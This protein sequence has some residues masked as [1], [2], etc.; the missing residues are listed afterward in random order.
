MKIIVC[1]NKH[2]HFFNIITTEEEEE[3]KRTINK[4]FH[5]FVLNE[6][7]WYEAVK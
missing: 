1:E 5:K 6:Y 4:H 2:C 3:K 7:R